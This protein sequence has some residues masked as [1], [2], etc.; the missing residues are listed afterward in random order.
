MPAHTTTHHHIHI[1]NNIFQ[2]Y[3]ISSGKDK[4]NVAR[5]AS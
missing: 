2:T 4:G 3:G 1:N 5:D